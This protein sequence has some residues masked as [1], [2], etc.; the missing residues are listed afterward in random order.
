MK[1][2]A[3]PLQRWHDSRS[4][5]VTSLRRPAA[6]IVAHSARSF[7][8]WYGTECIKLSRE[9]G[10]IQVV[11]IEGVL[12]CFLSG[13]GPSINLGI[14]K[15]Q[16]DRFVFAPMNPLQTM[17]V[18]NDHGVFLFSS[19]CRIHNSEALLIQLSSHISLQARDEVWWP[20][21][22]SVKVTSLWQPQ[23]FRS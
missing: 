13:S 20:P 18:S 11:A 12:M 23:L 8:S 15:G 14:F 16:G 2:H 10:S 3:I 22:T 4:I 6:S 19:P 9:V 7:D 21:N 17:R 5:H 1:P